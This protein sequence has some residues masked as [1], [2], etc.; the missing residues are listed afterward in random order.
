MLILFL[1]N[2]KLKELLQKQEI[3]LMSVKNNNQNNR[4]KMNIFYV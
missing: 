2:L 1:Q 4:N 3:E